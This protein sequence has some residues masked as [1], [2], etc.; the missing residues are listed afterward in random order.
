MFRVHGVWGWMKMVWEETD[1]T[2][3]GRRCHWMKPFL[4]ESV[5]V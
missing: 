2:G 5:I 1:E 3:F 4:D